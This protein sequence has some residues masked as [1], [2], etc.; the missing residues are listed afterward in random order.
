MKF[1]TTTIVVIG[2]AFFVLAPSLAWMATLADAID[3]LGFS[4]VA[5]IA[6]TILR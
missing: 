4:G 1:L 5:K 2:G 3:Y 6:R